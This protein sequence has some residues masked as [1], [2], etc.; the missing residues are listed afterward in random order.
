MGL[1]QSWLNTGMEESP[2][3]IAALAEDMA[4]RGVGVL[5]K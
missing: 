3:E 1:I 5:Q 2:E 4:L